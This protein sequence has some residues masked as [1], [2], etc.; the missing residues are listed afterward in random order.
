MVVECRSCG[1]RAEADEF[2]ENALR[3][4]VDPFS[5]IR[6]GAR[7][8]MGICPQCMQDTFVVDEDVCARCRSGRTHTTCVRCGSE[9][10]IEEQDFDGICGYCEHMTSKDD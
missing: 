7:D 3:D 9:L 6:D 8:S 4:G 2:V 10:D 5:P 1:H